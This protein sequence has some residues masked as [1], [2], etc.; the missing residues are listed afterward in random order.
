MRRN[1]LLIEARRARGPQWDYSTQQ[2]LVDRSSD[3]YYTHMKPPRTDDIRSGRDRRQSTNAGPSQPPPQQQLTNGHAPVPAHATPSSTQSMH[4]PLPA[5]RQS[6]SPVKPTMPI[7]AEPPMPPSGHPERR[8][9]GAQSG[10]NHTQPGQAGP[11]PNFAQAYNQQH[12]LGMSPHTQQQQQQGMYQPIHANGHPPPPQQSSQMQI[13]P[14]QLLAFQ[15]HQQMQ[16]QAQA[17]AQAQGQGQNQANP[18]SN[19]N[20]MNPAALMQ[21]QQ[22]LQQQAQ[23]QRANGGS[24]TGQGQAQGQGQGINMAALMAQAQAQQGIQGQGQGQGQNQWNP[25]MGLSPAMMQSMGGPMLGA[26]GGGAGWNGGQ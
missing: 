6:S 9:S 23:Q 25:N 18:G 22:R 19:P 7:T 17:Q 2:H 4:R 11:P 3:N 26:G 21:A 15:Q 16:R 13:D 14:A 5:H 10:S 24:G 12:S 1:H 20:M 8:L